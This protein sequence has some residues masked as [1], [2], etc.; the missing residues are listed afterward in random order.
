MQR[1]LVRIAFAALAALALG[2][3][4]TP[5]NAQN[6]YSS[7]K[8]SVALERGFGIH[9]VSRD[10]DPG[11]DEDGTVIGIGWYGALTP[12][13]WTRAALDGFIMDQ[14]SLGGSLGFF[15]Q[16]GDPDA[17]GFLFA[18]RVGYA[19]PI[20]RVFTFWPRGGFTYWDFANSSVFAL[21]A[22]GMFVAS[23][24]PN[25]GILFG[26]T[27]D[28]GFMGEAGDDVD[29]SEVAI[30]FPSVGLMGTF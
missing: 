5:S 16:S 10:W 2:L 25:W 1:L 19:I 17:D 29:F 15:S 8:I 13:H 30:G 20:S 4:A 11:G 18:P 6:F 21:A 12:F 14:L 3:T 9:H 7:G 24:S 26:P 28:L 23:P 22:E 27:I